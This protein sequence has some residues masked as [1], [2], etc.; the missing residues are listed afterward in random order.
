L[1]ESVPVDLDR[2]AT[3]GFETPNELK[4]SGLA[5]AGGA[6]DINKLS[7]GDAERNIGQDV[8]SLTVRFEYMLEFDHDIT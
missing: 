4:Q 1:F 8:A 3:W 2:S 5:S 6:S 7:G